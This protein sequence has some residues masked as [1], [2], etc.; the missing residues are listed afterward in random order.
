LFTQT[1]VTASSNQ[2]T[3]KPLPTG[4]LQDDV[5]DFLVLVPTD[6][7]LK[8]ALDY[9]ANDPEMKELVVSIHYEEF[10]KIHTIVEHLKE[11]KDVS[12]FMCM[13]LKP[14]SDREIICSV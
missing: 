1:Q 9:L 8:I 4:R 7:V 3:G 10:P 6:K 14:Q 11:Y 13:F 5:N 12:T 2:F